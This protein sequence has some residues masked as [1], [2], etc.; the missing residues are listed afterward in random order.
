VEG[1]ID[2]RV[3]ALYGVSDAERKEVSSILAEGRQQAAPCGG[4]DVEQ[5]DSEA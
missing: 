1:D 2:E 5:G 4:G 3:F